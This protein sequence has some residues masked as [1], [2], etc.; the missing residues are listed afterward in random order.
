MPD[1]T[2]MSDDELLE[3]WAETQMRAASLPPG[4]EPFVYTSYEAQRHERAESELQRRGYV[5]TVPG[6]WQRPAT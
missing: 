4:V 5:E 2:S 3:E 6:Y 1:P